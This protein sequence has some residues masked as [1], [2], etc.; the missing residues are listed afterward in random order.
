MCSIAFFAGCAQPTM[1]MSAMKPPERPK[2]LDQ[3]ETFVGNWTMTGEMT[4]AGKTMPMTGTSTAAWDC[5]R[6]IIVERGEANCG[7]MGKM[8]SLGI[9]GWNAQEKEFETHYFES[10]GMAAKGEMVWCDK[11][12]CWC[13]TGKGIEPMSG[14]MSYW[15]GTVKMPDSSTMD[16]TWLSKDGWGNVMMS[17]KGTA[18]RS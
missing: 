9:Y 8:T 11:N 17:G 4:M 5:D 18:K 14:K 7:D 6:R 12:K 15:S 10:T 16:W 13:M 2:E 3:L 1:D